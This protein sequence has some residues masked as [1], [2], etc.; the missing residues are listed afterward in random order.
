MTPFCAAIDWGTS[1]FRLWLLSAD[2]G[3]LAERRSDEG[4]IRAGA[5][6]FAEILERHL[7]ALRVAA[8]LPAIVC[9]MAGARQGWR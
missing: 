5:E 9:G 3:V 8:D 2:G 4:M 7:G 6:G 1:S